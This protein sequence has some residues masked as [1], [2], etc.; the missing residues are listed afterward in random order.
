LP[1]TTRHLIQAKAFAV[2]CLGS[3]LIVAMQHPAA[4]GVPNSYFEGLGEWIGQKVP[5][6]AA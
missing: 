6:L 2:T 4:R 1:S 3:T 5:V